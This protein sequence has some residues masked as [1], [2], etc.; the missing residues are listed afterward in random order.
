MASAGFLSRSAGAKRPAGEH[1]DA[2]LNH[3]SF[4]QDPEA[5]VQ[6]AQ[7]SPGVWGC[8]PQILIFKKFHAKQTARD[9]QPSDLGA[10]PETSPRV[11]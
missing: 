4:Q 7:P 10:R 6:R 2:I 11:L 9:A 8:P 5:G 1:E 3:P